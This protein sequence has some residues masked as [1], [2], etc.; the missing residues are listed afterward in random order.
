MEG[1]GGGVR[2]KYGGEGRRGKVEVWRGGKEG[3]RGG[4]VRWKY[5]GRGGGVRWKYGGE[6]R[7]EG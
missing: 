4:G 2:W 3:R 5:G 7:R 1:R 6:G